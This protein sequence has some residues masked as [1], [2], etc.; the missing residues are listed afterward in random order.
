MISM[1]QIIFASI[2]SPSSHKTSLKLELTL[3]QI[4]IHTLHLQ[5]FIALLQPQ[6]TH[7]AIVERLNLTGYHRIHCFD[8]SRDHEEQECVNNLELFMYE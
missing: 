5:L 8:S 7:S 4:T 6:G 3:Q 1:I 2:C